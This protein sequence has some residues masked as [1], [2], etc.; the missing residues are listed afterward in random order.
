MLDAVG[1]PDA[2]SGWCG[3]NRIPLWITVNAGF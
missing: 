3:W 2:L 1:K